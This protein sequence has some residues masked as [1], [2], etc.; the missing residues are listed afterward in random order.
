MGLKKS[1]VLQTELLGYA[2]VFAFLLVIAAVAKII[3]SYL[4]LRAFRRT[5]RVFRRLARK[6]Q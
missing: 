1:E 3:S 5:I 6:A 4:S 2:F